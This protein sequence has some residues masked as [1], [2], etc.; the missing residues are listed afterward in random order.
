MV[1]PAGTLMWTDGT[2]CRSPSVLPSVRLVSTIPMPPARLTS[3]DLATRLTTPRS[4]WTMAP[5]TFAGSRLPGVQSA[6]AA[7][8][9][10]GSA[11][12]CAAS[13]ATGP[14]VFCTVV[15]MPAYSAPLPRTTVASRG[16]TVLAATVVTQGWVLSM[17]DGPGPLL[18]AEALTKTPAEAAVRNAKA[19]GLS[20]GD[21]DPPPTE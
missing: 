1:G 9:A 7:A 17:V 3:A 20:A 12:F 21:S 10:G 8:V 16:P 5:V 6:A 18:P 13:R 14:T 19:I 4:H 15:L 2:L 11:L